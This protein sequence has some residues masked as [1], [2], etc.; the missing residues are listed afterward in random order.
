MLC[1]ISAEQLT[2]IFGEVCKADM[3]TQIEVQGKDLKEGMTVII[4][5][6][7]TTESATET[8]DVIYE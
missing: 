3:Y 7:T 8:D 5:D 4:P 6:A 2:F 1:V